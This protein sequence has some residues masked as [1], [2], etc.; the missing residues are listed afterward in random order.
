[1]TPLISKIY[2]AAID[3]SLWSD[4]LFD[5]AKAVG[6]NGAMVF[7]VVQGAKGEQIIAPHFSKNFDSEIVAAYLEAFNE[8]EIIDQGHFARLS[9]QAKGLQMISDKAFYPDDATLAKLPNVQAM[10]ENGLFRR[11][12]T[13]L[14]KD[15]WKIDR[16]ALQFGQ[17][18][19][20]ATTS[21]LALM[22][23]LLPHMAKS[24][25][26]G[27]PLGA[28]Y[29]LVQLKE[30]LSTLSFGVGVLERNGFPIASN[31][32]FDKIIEVHP[33]FRKLSTGQIEL[34]SEQ[35]QS[36]YFNLMKGENAH[37]ISGAYPRKEALVF[38]VEGG[39]LF[40][41]ICP[42]SAHPELGFLP[43]GTRL[44]TILDTS[45]GHKI[46]TEIIG[47]FFKLTKTEGHV[48]ELIAEGFSNIEIAEIRSRSVETIHSQTKSLFKKTNTQNRTELVQL[49]LSLNSPFSRLWLG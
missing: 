31:P 42:T 8:Q 44:M 7:E 10:M 26:V 30:R 40:V 5:I 19:G 6:A 39:T 22:N 32:V 35:N 47:R 4:T 43:E 27:R 28:E 45:K 49:A 38:D 17:D 9:D 34:R 15:F 14:N 29:K 37:G 12:G 24:L 46:K 21:E 1:M 20:P 48:L 36:P 23:K 18:H 25:R 2:D 16:F 41:E 3:P 13:L 11:A 33:I